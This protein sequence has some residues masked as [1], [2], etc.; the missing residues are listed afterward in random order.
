MMKIRGM[1][2]AAGL[3][4][5][6]VSGCAWNEYFSLSYWQRDASG[7]TTGVGITRAGGD[8]KVTLAGNP[9][10]VAQRFQ[11]ALG[12]LGLQVQVQ[13]DMQGISLTSTTKTGKQLIIALRQER[14]A[15]GREA[16]QVQMNWVGG[17]DQTVESQLGLLVR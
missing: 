10:L 5:L 2:R 9:E 15:D 6:V 8:T 11:Q 14:S 17:V 4:L 7:Q 12:R 3:A 16:T 13:T 1:V